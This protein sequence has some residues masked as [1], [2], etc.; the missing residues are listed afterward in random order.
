MNRPTYFLALIKFILLFC[1]IYPQIAFAEKAD[2]GGSEPQ[3][4]PTMNYCNRE[5]IYN[6]QIINNQFSNQLSNL[7]VNTAPVGQINV[8]DNSPLMQS[9][10]SYTLVPTAV[11]EAYQRCLSMPLPNNVQNV[12]LPM[13]YNTNNLAQSQPPIR[14]MSRSG[15][16]RQLKWRRNNGFGHRHDQNIPHTTTDLRK[17]LVRRK[18]FN[19][20]K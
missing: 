11:A 4:R 10:Q 15:R 16:K 17:K 5:K 19:E 1:N 9:Q 3:R 7:L 8:W 20:S 2:K 12:S 14:L 6:K 13:A 18:S